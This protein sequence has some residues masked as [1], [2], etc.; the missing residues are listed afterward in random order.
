MKRSWYVWAAVVG[1]LAYVLWLLTGREPSWT[2]TT[3]AVGNNRRK[4]GPYSLQGGT[5]FD[6]PRTA[7]HPSWLGIT[8]YPYGVEGHEC[9]FAEW[10]DPAGR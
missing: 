2:C 3:E 10:E 8:A 1:L 7:C 6:S 5:V 9:V 4:E